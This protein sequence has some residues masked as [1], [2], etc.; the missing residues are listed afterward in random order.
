VETTPIAEKTFMPVFRGMIW[1]N[2][3]VKRINP[4]SVFRLTISRIIGINKPRYSGAQKP[5]IRDGYPQ[6]TFT[7]N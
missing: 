2:P 6:K 4:Y 5:A 1:A 7:L 3:T